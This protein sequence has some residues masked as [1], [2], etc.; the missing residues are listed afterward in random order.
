M[1]KLWIPGICMIIADIYWVSSVW[2]GKWKQPAHF[3]TS[4]N[5]V[6]LSPGH[7]TFSFT[8]AR[9][10]V[11][12]SYNQS[13]RLQRTQPVPSC[14]SLL[15][16][17]PSHQLA[18]CLHPTPTHMESALAYTGSQT[19][20]CISSPNLSPYFP[21]LTWT[22]IS[23]RVFE[24]MRLCRRLGTVGN[25]TRDKKVRSYCDVRGKPSSVCVWG[26]R[27]SSE[28]LRLAWEVSKKG[29]W[30]LLIYFIC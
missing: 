26:P 7:D 9:C 5:A 11:F 4:V 27:R 15:Q 23:C 13:L 1:L 10:L 12:S 6:C 17:L 3:Y 29:L 2:Q 8:V 18:F 30:A 22:Q 20:L 24:E 28:T 19:K 21:L 14:M 16:Q 25:S